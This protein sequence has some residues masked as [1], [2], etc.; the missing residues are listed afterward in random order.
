MTWVFCCFSNFPKIQERNNSFTKQD[1][2]FIVD[3]TYVN[4]IKLYDD[5]VFNVNFTVRLVKLVDV[6]LYKLVVRETQYMYIKSTVPLNVFVFTGIL[7]R[8][9]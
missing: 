4:F 7:M 8:K 6:I 9:Q 1:V 3:I 2:L 5:P